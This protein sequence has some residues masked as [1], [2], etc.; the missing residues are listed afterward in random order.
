MRC[1]SLALFA[2]LTLLVTSSPA[3]V[4]FQDDFSGGLGNWDVSSD[5]DTGGTGTASIVY[6][7]GNARA[8]LDANSSW[9]AMIS[10]KQTFSYVGKDIQ[11]STDMI[12]ADD[13]ASL[14]VTAMY[15]N[16]FDRYG[17]SVAHLM[18]QKDETGSF[19][20][21]GFN[22][23][24]GSCDSVLLPIPNADGL[25]RGTISIRADGFVDYLVDGVSY[26]TS[27]A[28]VET[29]FDGTA[30]LDLLGGSSSIGRHNLYD[31]V[32]VELVPE[33]ATLTMLVIGGLAMIRRG[34]GR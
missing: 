3:A 18:I 1:C 10:S 26:W 9:W 28:T 33:P 30:S 32:L 17:S 4:L 12:P 20:Q 2:V 13:D 22:H 11:F 6:D 21:F 5:Q 24:D 15:V 7:G 19:A 14:H 8:L 31:N 34:R 27:T 29:A 25:H 16:M 23:L